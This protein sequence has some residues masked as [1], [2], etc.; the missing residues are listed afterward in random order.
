VRMRFDLWKFSVDGSATENVRRGIQ[1]THQT[2]QVQTPDA[3]PGDRELVYLSDSG[4]HGNLW[5]MRQDGTE[6][7]QVTFD[8]D[9][10]VS[11]GV[12]VWSPDGKNIAYVTTRN[13]KGWRFGLWLVSPDGSNNRLVTDNGGW[14]CWS[15]DGKWLYYGVP[16]DNG[17]HMEKIVPDG[18]SPVLVRTDNA[19]AGA[20]SP[21]SSTLYYLS[22]QENLTGVADYDVRMARPDNGPASLLSRIPGARVP[23]TYG[24]SIQPV[25]SPDGKS[26]ALLLRDDTGNINIWSLPAQGGDLRQITDF[27][28]RRTVIARRVSWWSDSRSI[29]AAV[30]EEDSDIVLLEGALPE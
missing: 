23:L 11:I 13:Q 5:I 27:G 25:A 7:R 21:D 29:V 12:P 4:G 1:L 10:N 20:I 26:L 30:A 15:P 24:W 3:G 2:G 28:Q 8:R 22:P 18:G 14:A 9:P 19:M 6:P 17:Y 16:T